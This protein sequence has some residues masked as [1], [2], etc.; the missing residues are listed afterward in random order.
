MTT[1]SAIEYRAV[2]LRYLW[3]AAVAVLLLIASIIV[4]RDDGQLFVVLG[5]SLLA[6]TLTAAAI[7]GWNTG[8]WLTTDVLT[9]RSVF[10][11]Q[12][13]PKL[14]IQSVD[15]VGRTRAALTLKDDSVVL[16]PDLGRAELAVAIN[17]WLSG[18]TNH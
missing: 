3:L 7:D 5:L 13:I 16:L 2:P 8:V 1:T 6:L 10:R 11:T 4:Y 9:T 12:S 14:R 18:E 17:R 15:R